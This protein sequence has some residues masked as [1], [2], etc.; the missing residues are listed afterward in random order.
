MRQFLERGLIP[1]RA[2]AVR[3][4]DGSAIRLRNS[5]VVEVLLVV[6]VYLVGV[7][8]IWAKQLTLEISSWYA[9]VEDGRPEAF[10]S[11]LVGSS[12]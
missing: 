8:F 12:W 9:E 6:F 11:G 5:I 10:V 4:R 3:L 7:L 2:P 1:A